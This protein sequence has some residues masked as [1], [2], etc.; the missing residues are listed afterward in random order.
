MI[1]LLTTTSLLCTILPGV[2]MSQQSWTLHQ[3]DPPYD[4][5]NEPSLV[6]YTALESATQNWNLCVIFP[7][8]KDPYWVATNFGV[9]QHAEQLGISVTLFE[10]G[11]YPNLEEQLALFQDCVDGGYDAILLGTV[12]HSEMTPAVVAAA[13]SVPVFAT[14]NQIQADGLSGM[15]AVNWVEMG[16]AAGR[17]FQEQYPAGS[18]PVTVAWVPGPET[19]GWVQFTDAGF[20]EVVDGA[21][22]EIVSVK[23]G[24][25]GREIQQE[26]VEDVLDEFPDVDYI[27]G[28]A[29]AIE[30]AMSVVRQRGLQDQVRLVA[31]YFTPAMLRGVRRGVIASAPTDSAALQ[32]VLSVDQAVRYLEGAVIADHVGPVI[33]NVD[34]DNV[35]DFPVDESLAPADFEPT[36]V[37]T[38]TN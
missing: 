16:R 10:A 29:V 15:T 11:G 31:D 18:S 6:E 20:R 35:R 34:S 32:G 33:F 17:Y 14:V 24:D 12:S 3:W 21:A 2:A 38:G 28:N 5:N 27:A 37:V 13:E 19:A 25:T 7:H 36:F 30:A 23:Y 4:F 8:L 22:V 1:K 9:M 26:L